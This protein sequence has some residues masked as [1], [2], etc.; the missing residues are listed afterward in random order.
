MSARVSQPCGVLHEQ[1]ATSSTEAEALNNAGLPPRCLL[2][3]SGRF[4][5]TLMMQCA[6]PNTIPAPSRL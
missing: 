3:C 1:R 4:E 6:D 2:V 5:E